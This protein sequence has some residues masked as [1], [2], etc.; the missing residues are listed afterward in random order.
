MYAISRSFCNYFLFFLGILCLVGLLFLFSCSLRPNSRVGV[1][2]RAVVRGLYRLQRGNAIHR[3]AYIA[4]SS[5][6]FFTFL[7]TH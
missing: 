2:C 3:A 4:M 6:I 5:T 7:L 1:D